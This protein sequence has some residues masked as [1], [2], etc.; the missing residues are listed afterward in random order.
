MNR[1]SKLPQTIWNKY[2]KKLSTLHVSVSFVI[3]VYT[4]HARIADISKPLFVELR[5]FLLDLTG[6]FR[7]AC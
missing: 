3:Q 1:H 2:K 7:F 5:F 4:G 6:L